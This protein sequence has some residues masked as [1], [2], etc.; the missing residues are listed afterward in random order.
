MFNTDSIL[1]NVA[2]KYS[3]DELKIAI[4]ANYSVDESAYLEKLL[5]IASPT[6]NEINE[7]TRK[8]VALVEKVR[9]N[10]SSKEGVEAFLQQYS[11]STKEGVI[12]MCLAEALLRIPDADVANSLINDKIKAAEWEKHLGQSDSWLVNTSTWG[13]MLTGKFVALKSAITGNPVSALKN[14]IGSASEPVIRKAMNQA[15]KFMGKQF[16]LGSSIAEAIKR[17]AKSTAKGYTHSFDMLGEAAYTAQDAQLYLDAYCDAIREIGA[18]PRAKNVPAPSISIKLS[19]LHPR[20]EHNQHERVM[21]E[22]YTSVYGLLKIARELDVA[23]TIDAEEADRL[24]ISLEL[25]EK[26]YQSDVCKDWEGFGIVVQAYSKRALPVLCWLN[27]LAKEAGR[28]IPLRL[29]KGAYW[30]SEIKWSQ[31]GG[32][33][34]YSVFTRKSATDVS[35]LAC[36]RYLLSTDGT[37]YPQFATHN[38]Q[39]VISIMQMAGTQRNFE[40]QRLHGMGEALYNTFLEDNPDVHCRI[41]A[42]VGK[43]KDLLP[44]LVRRLLEN[45]ANTSFVHKLVDEKTSVENLVAHP[46][47]TLRRFKQLSNERIPLPE[48]IYG[49][50]RKNSVGANLHINSQLKPFLSEVQQHL[51]SQWHAQPII[52]GDSIKTKAQNVYCPYDK[53]L[54]IGSV[55]LASA[56]DALRAIEIAIPAA[57]QWNAQGAEHRASCLDKFADL[58]TQHQPELMAIC[59][60]EGGKTLQDGIDEVREAID[61]ARYYAMQARK[62]FA[63]PIVLPGPT[64]ESNEIYLQGRGVFA[65]ISPWNFPLAIFVGQVSAALAA[66]NAVIAKPAGQTPIV[67]WRAIQL[68]HEAGIPTDVLNFVPGSGREI[69]SV[70]TSDPR[71]SGIAFTGSTDTAVHI[72]RSLAARENAPIVPFI[73]ETGGQNAMIVDSSALAEQVIDDVIHSAFTSAGQRCSALRVLFLQEDVAPRMLDVLKGAM[74]ELKIGASHELST[75]VGPV[76]DAASRQELLEHVEKLTAANQLIAKT[77][78]QTGMN[79]GHFITPTAFKIN[80]INDLKQEWF[81]PVLHVI[82]YQSKQLDAVIDS[83]NNYGYG[84]TLGIHSRNEKTAEYIDARVRVGNVYINRNMIGAVVGVQPFGG[85]GLSGTGPKAGGPRYLHRFATERTRTNNTAAIGGNTTLLS[86]GDDFEDIK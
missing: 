26:L 54:V 73:A 82:T 19:A 2:D 79:K 71:I 49:V 9:A 48:D 40:F 10:G 32:H 78:E 34:G 68:M 67:A 56:E 50:D 4:S 39:S 28:I 16:V 85:Q 53:G 55:K 44:Y 72:N 11:L 80:S 81:G 38:A 30:D 36:A 25:F 69:G 64:G 8:A 22:M 6:D 75:D 20:Y 7:V 83:I 76:I 77:P 41:Y 42:P 18:T 45:G 51:N 14:M 66:G 5:M 23:I 35:Y 37:F 24:E 17:G 15:M 62:D 60:R 46:C 31:Q 58:M 63:E 33:T 21:S 47:T 84:L 27:Q 70:L 65:C 43:H 59:S 61:F 29:V 57:I 1:P 74:Q 3:L 52:G 12:L 86:L 13:L